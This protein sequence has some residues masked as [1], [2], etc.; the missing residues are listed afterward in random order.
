MEQ[1]FEAFKKNYL[2]SGL[3]DAVVEQ[4]FNLSKPQTLVAGDTLIRKG[5]RSSDLFV[6]LDGIVD[7]Y[8]K[9]G[10]KLISAG[11]GSVLGEVALVDD[12]PRSA[13]AIC[14]GLV[15]VARFPAQDLRKYMASNREVGFILLANLARVLSMRLR[16]SDLVMEDLREKT[17]DYW[18]FSI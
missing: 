7:V 9:M 16:N 3:S 4:I 11:P 2:V 14:T 12:H 17:Q 5:D 6:I 10:D 15:K 18:K 1:T 8:T 13:D